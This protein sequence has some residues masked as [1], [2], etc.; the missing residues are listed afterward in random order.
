MEFR[1]M[2]R[3]F[4][5]AMAASLLLPAPA[6]AHGWEDDDAGRLW[7]EAAR[8]KVRTLAECARNFTGSL[9]VLH[10]SDNESSFV[11]PNTLEP[12][13]TNF[14]AVVDGLQRVARRECIP[15]LHVTAGDHTIPSPFYRASAEVPAYGSG[16]IGDILIYNAMKVRANGMGN[17]EFDGGIDDFAKMLARANYP[18]IAAN[19]DFTRAQVAD[20]TPPIRIGR[21]GGACFESRGKVVK[22]CWVVA[23]AQ[24]VGLIGLAPVDFF[25]IISNPSVTIPGIDFAGGRGPD[26]LPLVSPVEQVRE[27]VALLESRGVKR[28]ILLDHAQDFSP[29]P[30]LPQQLSGVDIIVTA[31]STGFYAKPQPDGPFN[32]L[33]PGDTPTETYPRTVSDGDGNTVLVVKTDQLYRYVGNLI[34]RFD[35]EGRIA[36]VDDR[37]GPVPSND[38]GI[39]ALGSLLGRSVEAPQAVSDTLAALQATPLITDAFTVIGSTVSPLNG[40]RGDVRTRETNLGRLAAD[41]T[42]WFARREYPALAVDVAIKNGGGIRDSIAG[43]SIIRLTVGAALLFD[44]KLAVL[45]LTGR[46]LLAAMENGVSR[47]PAADGRFPQVAGM[48]VDYA[49]TPDAART[50]PFVPGVAGQPALPVDPLPA[51]TGYRVRSLVVTR[52]NGDVVTI[53]DNGTINAAALDQSFVVAT[54]DFLSGGTADGYTSLGPTVATK[55]VTT[56]IGEQRILETYIRDALGGSVNLVDPPVDPRVERLP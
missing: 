40:L 31:G 23:G 47:I 32:L 17:H 16:G 35:R 45:Q 39:A 42:L 14:A 48:T 10:S 50:P 30:V 5:C 21:D 36:H 49:L 51:G 15:S 3:R 33:R 44:N 4:A 55:L 24:R 2:L 19:L 20:G 53:V 28:I 54:N 34:V 1:M 46:Q 56:T 6:F 43:P 25:N 9:Q 37:S 29:V 41:S 13:I 27:Q 52:A 7:R 11:D 8:D 18:F 38:E 22:S 12:K 26:Q